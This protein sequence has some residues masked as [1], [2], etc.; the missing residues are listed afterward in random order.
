MVFKEEVKIVE[1]VDILMWFWIIR[2][3]FVWI[4]VRMVVVGDV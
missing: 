3:D 4:L 1:G 2:L